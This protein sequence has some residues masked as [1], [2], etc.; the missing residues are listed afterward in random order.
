MAAKMANSTRM[1]WATLRAM[2]WKDNKPAALHSS[3]LMEE[4]LASGH[5]EAKR[6][7]DAPDFYDTPV[8]LGLAWLDGSIIRNGLDRKFRLGQLVRAEQ[9]MFDAVAVMALQFER[10][11]EITG[12]LPRPGLSSGNIEPWSYMPPVLRQTTS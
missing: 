7:I 2:E 6:F 5:V 10:T 12:T 1:L 9:I 11:L 8:G 3:L 4:S